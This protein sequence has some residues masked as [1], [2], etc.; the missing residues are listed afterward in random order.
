MLRHS[1]AVAAV[2]H[3]Q[4]ELESET[5]NSFDDNLSDEDAK[6][7]AFNPHIGRTPAATPPVEGNPFSNQTLIRLSN[8]RLPASNIFITFQ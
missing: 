3:L 2:E 8:R 7:P 5:E 4:F 6:S 1:V